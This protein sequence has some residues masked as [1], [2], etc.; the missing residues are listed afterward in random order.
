MIWTSSGHQYPPDE[1]IYW[2][3]FLYSNNSPVS[4]LTSLLTPYLHDWQTLVFLSLSNLYSD[5]A[6]T[7]SKVL[8]LRTFLHQN[9]PNLN[10]PTLHLHIIFAELQKHLPCKELQVPFLALPEPSEIGL[11][12]FSHYLPQKAFPAHAI[13]QSI[14]I[15]QL[16]QAHSSLANPRLCIQATTVAGS[17]LPRTV[18][19]LP[20]RLQQIF[21]V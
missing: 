13:I 18:T 15:I 9:W 3:C 17:L 4:L 2:I 1:P 5:L 10:F 21:L 6:A 7:H 19:L 20:R 11:T 16:T 14:C 12:S 8:S